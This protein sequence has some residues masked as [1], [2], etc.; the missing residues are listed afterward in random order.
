MNYNLDK[1]AQSASVTQFILD[2]IYSMN[3]SVDFNPDAQSSLWGTNRILQISTPKPIDNS[4]LTYYKPKFK[5][6]MQWA[7][8]PTRMDMS[9]QQLRDEPATYLSGTTG[10]GYIDE[11]SL[12]DLAGLPTREIAKEKYAKKTGE[13]Y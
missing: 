7:W 4:P 13:Y 11:G 1:S 2:P 5:D 8:E 6:S 3:Q 12:I 10:C 9:A